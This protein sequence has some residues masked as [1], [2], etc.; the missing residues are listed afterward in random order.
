MLNN[1]LYCNMIFLLRQVTQHNKCRMHGKKSD[2]RNMARI[3]L[4]HRSRERGYVAVAAI[5]DIEHAIFAF[6]SLSSFRAIE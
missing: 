5:V 1:T 4:I 3:I 2:K 6:L